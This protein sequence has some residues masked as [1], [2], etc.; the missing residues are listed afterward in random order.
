M[1]KK[2]LFGLLTPLMALSFTACGA[3]KYRYTVSTD[4]MR[5]KNQV[6]GTA[7]DPTGLVVFASGINCKCSYYPDF[8]VDG[9]EV[10]EGDT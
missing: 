2:T 8:T 3:P 5:F 10:I 7:F 9:P 6:R 4:G 1:K